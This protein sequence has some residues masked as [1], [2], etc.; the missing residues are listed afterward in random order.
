V[1]PTTASLANSTI[2]VASAGVASGSGVVVT[3][4]AVDG[5]G[6]PESMGGLR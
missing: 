5:Y 6:N 4:H 2:S 1:K 3:L